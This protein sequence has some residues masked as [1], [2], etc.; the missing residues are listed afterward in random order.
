MSDPDKLIAEAK[1]HL[2][3][4]GMYAST[5]ESVFADLTTRLVAALEASRT[6]PEPDWRALCESARQQSMEWESAFARVEAELAELRTPVT[7]AE[8]EAE[9]RCIHCSRL[10][11]EHEIGGLS[12]DHAFEFSKLTNDES[13][14]LYLAIESVIVTRFGVVKL[15]LA[16]EVTD[17]VEAWLAR[18]SP[19]ETEENW[20]YG[21]R[22]KGGRMI[23]VALTEVDYL[24]DG[25]R[26]A[27]SP[28]FTFVKRT[29][30][31]PAGPWLPV[32]EEK[33]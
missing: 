28:D 6:P 29:P 4:V 1:A 32:T 33:K 11:T 22:S 27:E 2:A 5:N 14:D 10:E 8:G 20:E 26:V 12:Q 23:N 21:I 17:A 24:R 18:R 16:E 25:P 13:I 30:E 3:D 19:V 15:G 7:P 31:V 9:T